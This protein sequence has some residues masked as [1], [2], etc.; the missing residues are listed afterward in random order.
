LYTLIVFHA[1]RRLNLKY[2][3]QA[4]HTDRYRC[5]RVELAKM[6]EK[7][8]SSTKIIMMPRRPRTKRLAVVLTVTSTAWLPPCTSCLPTPSAPLLKYQ[9]TDFVALIHF[10]MATFG[11]DGDPGCDISNW[12]ATRH[13]STF[14]PTQL[15]ITQWFDSIV[16]LGAKMAVLT[17]KHG[18]GF[19]LWPTQARLPDGSPYGYNTDT[20]LLQEFLNAANQHGIGYGYYYSIMKNF[21][22]CRDFHGNN[23]CT[24]QVLEGQF[25]V[26]HMEY[27][28]IVESHVRELWTQYGNLSRIWVDSDL[29][30]F[31]TLM[32][33]LQPWAAGTPAA[34][35][36]WCGTESGYPS[37]DVGPG[38]IWNTGWGHF[39]NLSSTEWIPKFCDPQL[40]REHKWFWEPGLTTRTLQ[41]M[42]VIYHDIVGRGMVMELAF[43]INRQGLVDPEHA[44]VYRELGDW[45]R[46]CYGQPLAVL[47]GA[48]SDLVLPLPPGQTLDRIQLMEDITLGERVRRYTIQLEVGGDMTSSVVLVKGT[49]IGR[50]R[51]HL[52]E[53]PITIV[54]T[55]QMRLVIHES[56]AE[57]QIQYFAI[58]APCPTKSANPTPVQGETT[59]ANLDPQIAIS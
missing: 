30:G 49:A 36:Q 45:V 1:Q 11:H 33:Q 51:I 5:V 52:L 48:G 56:V 58:F 29:G 15:N 9:S 17:A 44:T 38:P 41:D 12:N 20:D 57:P 22:L 2:K 55:I 25:N 34:D 50:K 39:G 43:S 46:S 19:C 3:P 27:H 47:S 16:A 42:I 23:T 31:G 4:T 28:S 18:C 40:F 8:V 37:R 53:S 26:T 7:Q 6:Q 13:A 59:I 14:H 10:N 21:Y 32:V 24:E 35:L 54:G